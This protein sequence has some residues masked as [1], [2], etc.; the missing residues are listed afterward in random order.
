MIEAKHSL[1]LLFPFHMQLFMSKKE[2]DFTAL[3]TLLTI[4]ALMA[5]GQ[6]RTNDR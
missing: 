2:K 4:E 3:T 1:S 6:S 5:N